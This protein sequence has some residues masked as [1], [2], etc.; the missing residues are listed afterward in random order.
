MGSVT[1][2]Q[3]RARAALEAVRRLRSIMPVGSGADRPDAR[4]MKPHVALEHTY[5]TA[6]PERDIDG[7]ADEGRPDEQPRSDI[8]AESQSIDPVA[9]RATTPVRA[10]ADAAEPAATSRPRLSAAPITI[11]A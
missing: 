1:R 9:A 11:R 5:P 2:Q 3:S 10:R 6:S 7:G 8:A 4:Q